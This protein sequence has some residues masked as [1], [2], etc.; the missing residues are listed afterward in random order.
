M[1]K[2][3]INMGN[4]GIQCI[5]RERTAYALVLYGVLIPNLLQGC[6]AT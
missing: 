5:Y 4:V 3:E 2:V 1:V 6:R